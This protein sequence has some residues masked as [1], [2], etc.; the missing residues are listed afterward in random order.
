M[1]APCYRC[2]DRHANCHS[3][4]KKYLDFRKIQDKA[5]LK[6]ATERSIS[7]SDKGFGYYSE[8]EKKCRTG[9]RI[10]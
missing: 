8:A 4:C 7:F 9:L 2:V 10:L 1:Y 5:N 3:E 6:K